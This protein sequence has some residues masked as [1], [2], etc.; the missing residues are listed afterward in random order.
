MRLIEK[1][2]PDILAKGAD[3]KA[4]EI[5]GAPEVKGWGGQVRRIRLTRGK[6][7]SELIRKMTGTPG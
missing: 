4:N 5:V 2:Q 3:Y 7:T 6:S 1:L